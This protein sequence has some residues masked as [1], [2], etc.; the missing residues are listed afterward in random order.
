MADMFPRELLPDEVKS[1]G[2]RKTFDALRDRVADPWQAYHSVSWVARDQ[3]SGAIDGEIDFVVC[4]PERGVVCLEVKGGTV[5]SRSGSWY[6][7]RDGE[8][9]RIK[10]PFTQALD[11]R[12][13]LERYIAA[14]DAGVA[15]RWLIGQAIVLPDVTVHQLSLAPDAPRELIIDRTDLRD[16][17][18]A[19]ERVVAFHRGI[20]EQR[21]APGFDGAATLRELLVPSVSLRV[22]MAEDLLEEEEAL[23]H[24]TAEQG[25]L[26]ARMGRTPRLAV[27]GCAGSGKTMLAVEHARRLAREGTKV[28]FVC[29]NRGLAEHLR[30]RE[31]RSGVTVQTFHGL[32]SQLARKAKVKLPQYEQGKAP[33]EYFERDLPDALVDAVAIL[34]PQFDALVVDEAQDLQENWYEALLCV[35][36]DERKANVWLFVDDNQRI[37]AS[38]FTP[39]DG[40]LEFELTVNCRNTQAIHREVMKLYSGRMVPDVKGPPGREVE[41]HHSDDQAATVGGLIERLC[42]VEEI[43][44]QDV[45]VLSAHGWENSEVRRSLPG[46]Y[47]ATQKRG[48]LGKNVYF[49]SI[50]AFKGLEAPVVIL[51]ELEDLDPET[52]DQQLYVGISRA[53]NHCVIVAPPAASA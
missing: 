47:R 26:L 34:G 21:Q 42:G 9:T 15:N 22:P 12:Y 30:A 41:L 45:V 4:H 29:F 11:H 36:D 23:I 40:F 39:P 1:N 51:C 31:S 43:P 14:A 5:E 3:T 24:L 44:P 35:L 50:R 2:E 48:E 53:R 17:E 13:A 33:P 6:G 52:R 28:L 18:A 7:V 37:Y 19:L 16:L 10:D 49:S 25:L 20:R 46:S 27:T 8:R 32:C 38:G